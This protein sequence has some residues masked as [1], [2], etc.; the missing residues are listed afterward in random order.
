MDRSLSDLLRWN[1]LRKAKQELMREYFRMRDEEE[2]G[3]G[4]LNPIS[5]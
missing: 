4:C 1:E 3:I 5:N 2:S